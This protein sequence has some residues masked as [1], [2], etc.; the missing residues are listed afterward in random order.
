M[1]DPRKLR[2]KYETPQRLWDAKRIEEERALRIE[3]GLR[4]VHE[5]WRMEGELKKLRR[6]ARKL[7][8]LGEKGVQQAEQILAKAKRYGWIKEGQKLDD[9]LGLTLREILERR[10]QTLVVKK[11]FAKSMKE[12]R[13]LIVHRHISIG[14]HKIKAPSYLVTMAEEPTIKRG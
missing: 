3:Y 11:G 12:S 1:G 7:H 4:S 6:E 14:D 5:L 13:Q 8:A 10:L 2:K 9:L